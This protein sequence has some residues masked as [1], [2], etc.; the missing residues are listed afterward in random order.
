MK[1][2]ST[3]KLLFLFFFK[4][5]LIIIN[6]PF[7]KMRNLLQERI[8][9]LFL[10]RKDIFLKNHVIDEASKIALDHE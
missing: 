3:Y 7:K 9:N 5:N 8:T 1:N 4:F 2:L 6:I 10:G